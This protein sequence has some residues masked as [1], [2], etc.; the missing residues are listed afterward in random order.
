MTWIAILL[1]LALLLKKR[2]TRL[3]RIGLFTFYFFSLIPIFQLLAGWWEVPMTDIRT[4][5]QKY[6]VGI[7]LGGFSKGNIKPYDRLHF[8]A[9]STRITTAIELYKQGIIN[10]ILITGGSFV[11]KEGQ[12]PEADRTKLFLIKM[13]VPTADIIIEGES[14]NT[15]ENAIFTK[16]ILDQQSPEG[17][18]L[19]ITSAFHMRR[20][21]ACFQKAG[22]NV[23]TFSTDPF[24][25]RL[26]TALYY[27][28][29]PSATALRGWQ[30]VIKEWFGYVSY[31]ILGYL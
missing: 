6:D 25:G 22:V 8:T 10:K 1:T 27:Y 17:S 14:L 24:A 5:D 20:A 21:K 30:F 15:H 16:K 11:V 13:G 3:L 18:F 4:I 23:T 28:F 29:F 7:V 9:T 31:K 2:R 12:L 26:D 19:L